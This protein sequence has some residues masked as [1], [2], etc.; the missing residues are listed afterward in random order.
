VTFPARRF[1]FDGSSVNGWVCTS[2]NL[3]GIAW[4][5]SSD[6]SRNLPVVIECVRTEKPLGSSDRAWA[7]FWKIARLIEGGL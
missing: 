7:S 3:P 2:P 5:S 6:E 4:I 1:G